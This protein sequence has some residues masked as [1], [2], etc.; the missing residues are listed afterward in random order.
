MS[1]TGLDSWAV[2][3]ADV[4]AVYP[5]QGYEFA[6]AIVGIV[7]WLCWHIWQIK[8]ENQSYEE[9]AAKLKQHHSM[10]DTIKRQNSLN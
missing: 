2:D 6:M 1:T 4:G 3:L 9:D 5:F 8:S 10:E 7:L